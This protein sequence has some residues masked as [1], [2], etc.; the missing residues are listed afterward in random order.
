M[1]CNKLGK[2]GCLIDWP[3]SFSSENSG[4][5]SDLYDSPLFDSFGNCILAMPF[6][7]NCAQK[8]AT[9]RHVHS[10][11]HHRYV[12]RRPSLSWLRSLLQGRGSTRFSTVTCL[13]TSGMM[14]SLTLIHSKNSPLFS[15]FRNRCLRKAARN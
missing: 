9:K 11:Y 7:V 2:A 6:S 10:A 15:R 4:Q 12:I 3:A 13:E 14:K 5:T 1:C 8:C